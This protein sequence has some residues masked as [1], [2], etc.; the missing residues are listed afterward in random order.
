[1]RQHS[2]MNQ[3]ISS[4]KNMAIVILN[5]QKN[6]N[7]NINKNTVNNNSAF[8]KLISSE[9]K[10]MNSNFAKNKSKSLV[11]KMNI[12]SNS[13]SNKTLYKNEN[14]DE[15]KKKQNIF[16][17]RINYS[18]FINEKMKQNIIIHRNQANY[19]KQNMVNKSKVNN[20]NTCFD[21]NH[22]D[23]YVKNLLNKNNK[24][25][26]IDRSNLININDINI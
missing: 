20:C 23:N 5:K 13:S 14:I 11:N 6:N 15:R 24:S 22:N 26:S 21:L 2:A 17:R 10:K 7:N 16:K 19:L 12:N 1:M 9:L 4:D 25:K 18:N 3:R 8:M